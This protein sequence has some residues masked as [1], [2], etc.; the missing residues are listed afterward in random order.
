[1]TPRLTIPSLLAGLLLTAMGAAGLS[2]P[3][4]EGETIEIATA[5]GAT[6]KRGDNDEPCV[7]VDKV[8]IAGIVLLPPRAVQDAV[9]PHAS[10]CIGNASARAIVGAVNDLYAADGYVTTQAYV[11][12]QDLK[13]SRTLRVAIVAG[14][15][16]RVD[17]RETEA[18]ESLAQAWDKLLTAAGP[19]DGAKKASALLETFDNG[20]DRFQLI[21]PETAGGLKA[22]LALP[23]EPGDVVQIDR[24]QQGIDQLNRVPSQKTTAKL[25]PGDA[26]GTS[27][28]VLTSPRTDSFR[29]VAGY[30]INGNTL[31]GNGTSPAKRARLD[32]FKDNLIGLNDGWATSYAGGLDSNELRAAV[33]VP[34]RWLTLSLD[35]GYSEYLTP[36][37]RYADLFTQLYT[38]AL[39]GSV[40]L[41]RDKAQ[42]TSVDAGLHWRRLDR[43]INDGALTPQTISFLRVGVTH[44]RFSE[45]AQFVA[46]LGLS[47]GLRI[48]AATRDPRD[49][50]FD[51]PR[52]QFLK[53]DG[54]LS[55]ARALQE[56]GVVKLD[57]SGQW[58]DAPLYS[59]DQLILGSITTVRGF[60]RMPFRADRGMVARGEFASALPMAW[61]LGDRRGDLAFLDELGSAVQLYAFANL[62]AG[63]AIAEQAAGARGSIGGGIRYRQGRFSMDVTLAK[64]V[65]QAGLPA[66]RDTYKPELYLTASAQ[67][68]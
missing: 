40:M 54:L 28:V 19:W 65:F 3:R 2:A 26:P 11:P 57:L 51:V 23:L 18:D 52:A 66:N 43:F 22:W 36:I 53:L 13:A 35:G 30:E 33:S 48:L 38:G 9:A 42:Q 7:A 59:D 44:Q 5:F 49:P 55:Y 16:G 46:A 10:S 63:R 61:I 17:Y 47:Q 12:S 32:V 62:G 39:N 58:T 34:V 27:N 60:T 29:M 6:Q 67:L 25:E 68:F 56:I 41:S 15:V 14:R 4:V 1:M 50:P 45:D 24:L 64:P 31:N 8:V 37:G 21:P 20:L